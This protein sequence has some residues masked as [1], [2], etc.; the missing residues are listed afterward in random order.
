MELGQRIKEARLELGLTQRQLCGD[1]ITRNMLSQIESGS[2]RPSMATLSYLASRL[3]KPVSYFLEE[4]TVTSPNRQCM[5]QARQAYAAGDP[6]AALQTLQT[7]RQPDETFREEYVL[8]Q[9]LCLVA[10]G[11]K[12]LKEQRLPYALNLLE[13]AQQLE[14]MYITKP[15]Q[16]KT[17]VLSAMAGRAGELPDVDEVLLLGAAKALDENDGARA[18]AMLDSANRQQGSRWQLLRGR[19]AMALGEYE[20]AAYW[21]Q[22]AQFADPREAYPLLEVCFRELG[23]FRSAY[24]YACKQRTQS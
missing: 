17:Q 1:V 22:Q 18:A 12:M 8:L 14:G 5:T 16:G 24:E 13:Q 2:A 7:F 19:A 3:E 20:K 10:M 9:Y 23:D 6:A 11:E 4:H 21:L 15:L